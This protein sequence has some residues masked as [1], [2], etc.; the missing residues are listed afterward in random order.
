MKNDTSNFAIMFPY[1]KG[2]HYVVCSK[3]RYLT[4]NCSIDTDRVLV[5]RCPNCGAFAFGGMLDF[6]GAKK[7]AEKRFLETTVIKNE[8]IH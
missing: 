3:C 7:D 6:E 8:Q 4:K 2:G 1:D 5:E